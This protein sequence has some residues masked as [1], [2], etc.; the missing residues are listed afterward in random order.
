MPIELVFVIG[1]VILLFLCLKVKANAFISLLATAMVMGVLSGMSGS[2]TVSSIT[3][4]FA[5]TVQSIGIVIIFGILLGNYLDAAKGTNRMAIDTVRLVGQKRAGLAMAITGYIISIPVFADAGFVILTPLVKAIHKKTRIPLA[6]LA[7]SLSAGLLATHVYV[8]PTPG[9]L[10]A[11]GLLGIDIGQAILYG[12]FAAVF[13][14]AFG[15][16]F[17]ELYFRNKP[18]SYYTFRDDVKEEKSSMDLSDDK[19]LP[20]SLA[21]LLP[22]LIPILLIVSNTTCSMLLPEGSPV[23]LITSFVGDSNIAMAIGAVLAI[24]LLGKRM[25]AKKILSVMDSTLKDAGPIVFTTAAGG[26]LGEVLSSSGAGDSLASMVISTGLP[27]ILIPF[28]ISGLLKIVQ[29][30]GTVAV[31]TAATLCAP[32]AASLGLNPILIFLASG[33]GA[34]ACCHVNDS[35]FWV[36]TNCMGFDMKTGLK[37][38]SISNVFMALGRLCATFIC[39]LWL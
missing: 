7:V 30:S 19:D 6:I 33:A 2:E 18:E 11:A 21:S 27:F 3:S 14:T 34:R 23:L 4:G 5:G 36:Y 1:I 16:I 22:L 25:G 9:P 10:A 24:I 38:L 13:M 37:T 39:S 8:P 35:F 17:A 28:V 31:T 32:I 29:G 15:W 12:A 26:A 20:G